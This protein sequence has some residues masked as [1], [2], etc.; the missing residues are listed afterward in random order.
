MK[1]TTREDPAP[2]G[3]RPVSSGAVPV[4]KLPPTHGRWSAAAQRTWRAWGETKVARKW[5]A[6]QA[7]AAARLLQ[8][9]DELAGESIDADAR[10]KLLKELRR[11]ETDLGLR[12]RPSAKQVPQ[13]DDAAE[14][15]WAKHRAERQQLRD[16]EAE[17]VAAVGG[18]MPQYDLASMLDDPPAWIE[19]AYE[20]LRAKGWNPHTRW[21]LAEEEA[22]K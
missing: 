16:D 18:N 15:R 22:R 1:K 2:E 3:P 4:V 7:D 6:A 13:A 11:G 8:I 9:V 20:L 19:E 17:A 21:S 5:D 10:V 12:K 14:E